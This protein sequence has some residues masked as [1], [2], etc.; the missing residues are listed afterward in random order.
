MKEQGSFTYKTEKY[1]G[2]SKNV[3]TVSWQGRGEVDSY[4][5]QQWCFQNF[6][7]PGYQEEH[8]ESRWLD[9]TKDCAIYLCNDEDLTFFLLKW[10]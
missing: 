2:S 8:G 5:I 6:G 10:T 7:N 9:A 3:H 1:Y 4:E